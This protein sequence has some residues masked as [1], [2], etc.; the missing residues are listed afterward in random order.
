MVIIISG[1]DRTGKTTF[2]NQLKSKLINYEYIHFTAPKTEQEAYN[3]YLNFI[4]Q[5]N[6][7]KLY[8]IDRFYESEKV[9]GPIYRNYNIQYNYDF[10]KLL[11]NK[12][13]VLFIYVR[14]DL[15][16]IKQRINDVGDELVSIKDVEQICYNFE[17]Y[18]QNIQLPFIILNN[19]SFTDLQKNINTCISIINNYNLQGEYFGNIQ[20]KKAI[21][22]LNSIHNMHNYYFLNQQ[23]IQYKLKIKNDEINLDNDYIVYY[24]KTVELVDYTKYF[25]TN[26]I[27]NINI[28]NIP[29]YLFVH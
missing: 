7:N 16:I 15:D 5:L 8:I 28:L 10:D 14:A 20:A 27:D 22:Y 23:D 11:R 6:P 17:Q 9:Y 18:M 21:V 25:Y 13:K 4:N 29:D 3:K 12:V 24:D 2:C 1:C 26:N 19:N